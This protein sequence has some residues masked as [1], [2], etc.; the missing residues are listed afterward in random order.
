MQV[1][2]LIVHGR[3]TG[4]VQATTGVKIHATGNVEADL[5]TPT[6]AVEIGARFRGRCDMPKPERLQP[7]PPAVA[8][9]VAAAG[10]AGE[11]LPPTAEA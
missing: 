3:L 7:A 10:A 2:T 6:L 9:P 1:A 8:T 5:A 11:A 4:T